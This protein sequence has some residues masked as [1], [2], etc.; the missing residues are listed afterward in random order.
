[1][2]GA[3]CLAKKAYGDDRPEDESERPRLIEQYQEVQLILQMNAI[4]GVDL[5]DMQRLSVHSHHG[6]ATSLL[7]FKENAVRSAKG[8]DPKFLQHVSVLYLEMCR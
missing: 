5:S 3:V 4:D 1:M 8:V 2:S 6:A 7:D